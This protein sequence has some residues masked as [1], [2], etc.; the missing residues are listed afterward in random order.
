M[1]FTSS[2]MLTSDEIH[3]LELISLYVDDYK[4]LKK[5]NINLNPSFK[6]FF[7][8]DNVLIVENSN[9]YEKKEDRSNIK[10]LCGE[11]GVGKSTVLELLRRPYLSENNI[12]VMKTED[13][14]FISNNEVVIN[15][16]G[17]IYDCK[18]DD[19]ELKFSE[20]SLDNSDLYGHGLE[21]KR[22]FFDFYMKEKKLFD[23]IDSELL[24]NF[25]ISD[26]RMGSFVED[27]MS[28]IRN[29]L[30]IHFIDEHYVE[31]LRKQDLFSFLF[32]VHFGDNTFDTWLSNNSEEVQ[33]IL[34]SITE[35]NIVESLIS[36]KNLFFR[37]GGNGSHVVGE[38]QELL[39]S[40]YPIDEYEEVLERFLNI[41][42][43]FDK[44]V[45]PFYAQARVHYW[46][47]VVRY[48]FYFRGYKRII[49]EK[50]YLENLSLGEYYSVRSRYHLFAKMLQQDSA[51][52][53]EDEPDCHLH[54]EWA[55]VFMSSFVD[56]VESIRQYLG[57]TRDPLY[58][59][60]IYNFVLTTHSPLILS[61][62]FKDEVIF[63]RKVDGKVIIEDEVPDCFAGNIGSLLVDNFFLNKVIGEYA[64]KRIRKLIVEM[65]HARKSVIT[66]EE[67]SRMKRVISCIGDRLLRRLLEEKFERCINENY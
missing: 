47:G 8:D 14:K 20:L 46:E 41:S 60:K 51:I 15:Y 53:L 63:F 30:G 58:T 39:D 59:K 66:E 31:E 27:I 18:N 9:F 19:F 65:D 33:S 36:I 38:L 37:A 2:S 12:L 6:T 67:K 56:S 17:V 22:H 7:D 54:P 25:L 55:R 4:T 28:A 43:S 52:I 49:D 26:V 48:S 40:E 61:D 29:K 13:D 23:E 3:S 5:I 10:L 62:F 24:T 34:F 11:N 1:P 44:A 50:R 45:K 21:F 32:Y 35:L 16:N 42:D 57:E 64:E